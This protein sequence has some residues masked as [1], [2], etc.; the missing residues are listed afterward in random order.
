[1]KAP[2]TCADCGK[3]AFIRLAADDGRSDMVCARCFGRRR[4][5]SAKKGGEPASSPL[6]RSAP[7]PSPAPDAPARARDGGEAVT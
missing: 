2:G 4:A 5:E 7:P 3:D 6:S 1:M